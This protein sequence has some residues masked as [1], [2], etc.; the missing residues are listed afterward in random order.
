MICVMTVSAEH[1]VLVGVDGSPSSD[2]AV[3]WAARTAALRETRLVLVHVTPAPKEALGV[4]LIRP[5]E[6]WRS[7]EKTAQRVLTESCAVAERSVDAA[8]QIETAELSDDVVPAL[9]ALSADAELLVVGCR[10]LG[11][12]PRRLLGS[13]SA[14]L[15]HHARCPVVIVHDEKRGAPEDVA[16]LPVVA[17]VDGSAASQAAA[18]VAFDEAAR[19]DVELIVLHSWSENI[20]IELPGKEW[21][22]MHPKAVA[23]LDEW[24]SDLQQQYPQVPVRKVVVPDGAA[25]RLVKHSQDAQLVVVG[26]RG[27]GGFTGMLLGS[28]SAAVVEAAHTPVIVVRAP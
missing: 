11:R 27:R 8:L 21:E 7:L 16:K 20:G 25:R 2:A 10:G 17:G 18:A 9:V 13:V 15:A 24:L 5:P 12:I 22:V 14:G 1:A 19:R 26:S 3:A 4:S 23:A 6:V 28:V